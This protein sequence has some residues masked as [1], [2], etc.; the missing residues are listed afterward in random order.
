MKRLGL[1]YDINADIKPYRR[2]EKMVNQLFYM[3]LLCV[4]LFI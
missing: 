3:S 1:V 4:Y 2:M